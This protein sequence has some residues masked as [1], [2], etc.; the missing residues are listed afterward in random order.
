MAKTK[1]DDL[2]NRV[3]QIY[4]PNR[5]YMYSPQDIDVVCSFVLMM[6]MVHR[7]CQLINN[8]GSGKWTACLGKPLHSK[9]VDFSEKFSNNL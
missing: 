2:L 5:I 8:M 1:K 9:K 6:Y 4:L 7:Q 3:G